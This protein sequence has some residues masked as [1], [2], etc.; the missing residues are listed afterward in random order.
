MNERLAARQK[1]AR[2]HKTRYKKDCDEASLD[3]HAIA[4]DSYGVPLGQ[5]SV[6]LRKVQISSA[7]DSGRSTG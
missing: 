5:S 2:D 4:C 1:A 7:E 6:L 3:F